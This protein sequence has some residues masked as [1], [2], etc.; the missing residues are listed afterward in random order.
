MLAAWDKVKRREQHVSK[1]ESILIEKE[2]QTKQSLKSE[3]LAQMKA[4]QG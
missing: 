2:D 4:Q 1:S 3:A